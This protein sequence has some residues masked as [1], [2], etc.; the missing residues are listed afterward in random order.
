MTYS[1]LPST[2][3]RGRTWGMGRL[4]LRRLA[5]A[6]VTQGTMWA[7]IGTN[8]VQHVIRRSPPWSLSANAL[9]HVLLALFVLSWW[10]TMVA[11]LKQVPQE[12]YDSA[13][14]QSEVC[15]RTGVALPPRAYIF[16][17]E[18]ILGFDHFCGWLG[19][20]VALHNRKAFVL[21]LMYGC[22]LTSF[23]GVLSAH[24][25]NAHR[26]RALGLSQPAE[27]AFE[28]QSLLAL[29]SPG[30]LIVTMY[31]G[32]EEL[33][34]A[35]VELFLA[36]A[37]MGVAAGLMVF[38]LYHVR[39]VLRNCTSLEPQTTRWDV[40]RRANWCQVFGEDPKWWFF[41][42]RAHS[43]TCDGLHWPER[44]GPV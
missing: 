31:V 33:K 13:H 10:H 23:A 19:V 25:F 43:S 16:K 2:A 8:Y 5:F 27:D 42:S 22:L 36:V 21:L 1:R 15:K 34:H 30:V 38:S 12:W 11:P 24:D 28:L 3:T 4:S 44:A 14:S 6:S 20:P 41:P 9:G 37:D 17:D 35:S 40:G 29:L 7:L 26:T 32:F 18:V 39:L